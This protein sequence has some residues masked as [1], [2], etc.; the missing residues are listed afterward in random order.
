MFKL[1]PAPKFPCEVEISTPEGPLPLALKFKH[2][3]K[4]AL[5]AWSESAAGRS[6]S[7]FLAEVIADWSVVNE[8]GGTVPFSTE[9]L[10]GLL[11]DY[12]PAA[13]QIYTAYLRAINEGREKN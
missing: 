11:D 2:K 4:T 6:D 10:A 8:Q 12:P 13:R 9:A 5:K 7:D 3:G 1:N